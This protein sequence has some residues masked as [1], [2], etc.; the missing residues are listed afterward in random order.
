MVDEM[1]ISLVS[2]IPE[3]MGGFIPAIVALTSGIFT[4]LMPNDAYFTACC[5]FYLR[6]PW[7]TV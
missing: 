3:Q 1:A 7:R 5:P 2:L 4:F 6:P